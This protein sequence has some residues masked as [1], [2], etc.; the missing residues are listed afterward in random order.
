MARLQGRQSHGG[1][2]LRH[3]VARLLLA[4][5][6]AAVACNQSDVIAPDQAFEA[7]E[8]RFVQ[9]VASTGWHAQARAL[10]AA[11]VQSP[12]VAGRV[13]AALGVAQYDAVTSVDRR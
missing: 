7:Q 3:V 2:M 5:I 8:H 6:P 13:Y 12:L 9:T 10:V 1:S 4:V 11:N